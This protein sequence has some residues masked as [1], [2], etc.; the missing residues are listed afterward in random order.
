M[1]GVAVNE[2][3]FVVGSIVIAVAAAV[4]IVAVEIV[5]VERMAAARRFRSQQS[6]HSVP[7]VLAVAAQLTLGFLSKHLKHLRGVLG[8]DRLLVE[9]RIQE[10]VV[11]R[12]HLMALLIHIH[13]I[14]R[15]FHVRT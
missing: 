13:Q 12:S 11:V 14:R 15:H 9:R 2:L 7:F 10:D 6:L 5:A 3:H 4:V 8:R 1:E